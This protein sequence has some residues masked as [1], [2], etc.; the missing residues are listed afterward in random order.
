MTARKATRR[1]QTHTV[2]GIVAN[3]QR[4]VDNYPT[5]P[6]LVDKPEIPRD[7]KRA[8]A[9]YANLIR[10]R[11]PESWQPADPGRV[12]QLSVAVVQV[13]RAMQQGDHAAARVWQGIAAQLSRQ[14]GLNTAVVDPRLSAN[15]AAARQDQAAKLAGLDDPLGLLAMP[16][17][18]A[19]RN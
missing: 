7:R 1:T 13:G 8:L 11:V 4:A 19:Q 5:W 2:Q 3:L 6:D 12:A 9:W 10:H 15:A 17:H 18:P 14:L 16:V